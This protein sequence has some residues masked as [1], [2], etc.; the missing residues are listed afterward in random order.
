MEA[1]CHH[2]TI[3]SC[4][5][6]L[7]CLGAVHCSS[8]SSRV[9]S[10]LEQSAQLQADADALYRALES[11]VVDR[12]LPLERRDPAVRRLTSS[13]IRESD[14]SRRRYYL[15]VI[16]QPG[17][18]ALRVHIARERLVQSEPVEIWESLPSDEASLEE[19]NDIIADVYQ[20]WLSGDFDDPP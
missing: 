3:R 11:V 18:L 14:D 6:G 10:D 4:L 2:K 9:R 7:L 16:L 8:P 15:T 13:W 1:R 20:S 12:E 17:V 19:E 5:L